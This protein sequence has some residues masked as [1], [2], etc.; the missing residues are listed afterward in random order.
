[1]KIQSLSYLLIETTDLQE[2]ADYAKDVV[3]L[4]KNDSLSDEQNLFLRM[5]EKSFRFH[6]K[7]GSSKKYLAAGFSLSDKAAFD[8]AKSELDKAKVDYE[9]LGHEIAKLRCVEECIGLHDPAG[10][11]LELSYG[12]KMHL[13]RLHQ[14]KILKVSLQRAWALVMLF[15]PHQ[16]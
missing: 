11:R 16:I 7:T 8:N 3:G 14:R 10:N 12:S 9:D 6:I 2:W 5:D 13:N 1:M 4:M 15:L